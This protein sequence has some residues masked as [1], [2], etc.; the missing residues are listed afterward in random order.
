[1]VVNVSGEAFAPR[2]DL[3]QKEVVKLLGPLAGDIDG[4]I[5]VEFTRI[6]GRT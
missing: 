4:K 1:M 2:S 3:T 5:L 6:N